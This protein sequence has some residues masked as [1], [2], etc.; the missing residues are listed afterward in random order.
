MLR[1]IVNAMPTAVLAPAAVLL[2]VGVVLAEVWLVRRT[3]PATRE[4][5]DAEVSSQMLGVVASLFGL[6][7]AFVVV[8][9]YQNF[10]SAQ[11]NVRQ[12]A[13][14]LAAIV[15]DSAALTPPEGDRVRLAIG[16][17]IGAVVSDE[18][19]R[20]REGHDSAPAW[21]AIGGIYNA[22]QAA[23]PRSRRAV[24]FYDDSVRQLNGALVARRDRLAAAGAGLPSL[25]SAFILV[26]AVAILGYAAMVGSRSVW[27]HAVGAASIALVL[28]FTLVVL[29]SLSFPFSGSLAIT[30]DSFATGVL[31]QFSEPPR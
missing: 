1:E 27:F 26:G 7:L 8:T 23:E 10:G 4:G 31:A 16:T 11:D 28:G 22:L 29:L 24:A 13:D 30:S 12:E 2:T 6:L 17:Y 3:V 5:F 9:Q 25:M 20:M 15:R 14:A 18:W 19:P 21:R